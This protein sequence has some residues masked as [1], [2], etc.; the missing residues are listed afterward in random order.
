MGWLFGRV[1]RFVNS[2]AASASTG[3]KRGRRERARGL[4]GQAF[5]SALQEELS[6]YYRLIAVLEAQL[7]APQGRG[8]NG[9][10]LRRLSVWSQDPLERLH[11]MATL[12]ESVGELRGGAL[13]SAIDA[14]MRHGDPFVR[15]FVSRT[16]QRVC[17]PLLSIVW[18]WVHEGELLDPHQ[19]FFVVED[20][21]WV[22]GVRGYKDTILQNL[23]G[24][25]CAG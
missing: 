18:R 23:V 19:E 3:V 20:P 10:T 16:L 1:A 12:V 15:S 21:R 17:H 13:A 11:L 5:C 22:R 25:V 6:D 24:G 4:L 9:L 8:R 14:H 2:G 7:H